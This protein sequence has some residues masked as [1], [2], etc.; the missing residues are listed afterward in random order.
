M[1]L[2]DVVARTTKASDKRQK[3]FDGGGLFL[4]VLPNGSKGWRFKYRFAGKEKLLSLG[5]YPEVSLKLA[6][7]RR[8]LERKRVAEGVDPSQFRK[9]AKATLIASA[10][11]SF[12]AV[13][14]E[15]YSKNEASW[16]KNH[17]PRVIRRL[18]ADLFP[19]VGS[20]P[21]NE[22]KAPEFLACLRRI[23]SRGAVE[24]AH[25]A[26]QNCGQVM[27]YAVASGR[28][29]GDPTRDLRGAL[30]PVAKEHFAAVT[31]PKEAA[32]LLRTLDTYEGSFVVKCA[33]RLAPLVFVR[34]GELRQ[35]L[36][37]DIDL[38]NAEWRYDVTKTGTA[39]IVP[40]ATQAVGILREL[41][42]LTRRG[43]FV[44]PSAR[45][46]VRPMSNNAI[47]AALRRMG[48]DSS[49]MTG[50]GFRAMARTILDEVLGV[51]V[52]LIEHQ[53]AHAVKDANG[54]AYNR[55]AH[56]AERKKM[57][58]QWANYLDQ[59]KDGGNVVPL[60]KQAS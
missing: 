3:L 43:A 38:D 7:E 42:P 9:V 40:L 20:R 55:T 35:A 30:Q 13:A 50:H 22:L 2:T 36:W 14:R 16:A 31:E 12:E 53:L 27:R 47:L 52:H 11:N 44:F 58:Q 4:E 34:P 19:W 29:E 1:P 32:A 24:T 23:E 15:W 39:H 8:D 45:T 26:L 21:V 49:V 18:E 5:V 37:A 6:R 46:E 51:P 41:E 56:L 25:R 10:E 57:M 59:I 33:L 54:R 60:A 48:F 28:A 17:G